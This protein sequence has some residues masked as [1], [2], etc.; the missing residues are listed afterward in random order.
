MLEFAELRYESIRSYFS[1]P[2]NLFGFLQ[3]PLFLTYFVLTVRTHSVDDSS[4]IDTLQS[5]IEIVL[6]F[7]IMSK[8]LEFL[9]TWRQYR[10]I[11]QMI[12]QV[13]IDIK[14]FM[15]LFFF[16]VL[17]FTVCLI[18]L[19]GQV[20][21]HDKC[22]G[23]DDDYPSIGK[24]LQVVIQVFRNSIGDIAPPM[25]ENW[26]D[27]LKDKEDI[28]SSIISIYLLWTIWFINILL[29]LIVML[30]FLIAEVG[31]TYAKASTLG[32]KFHYRERSILNYQ[33]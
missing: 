5:I 32:E 19:D 16:F 26:S 11:I 1:D 12:M 14:P 2:F 18:S 31:N 21:E 6:F 29:M 10:F 7:S 33:T 27:N 3:F 8:V 15:I 17:L 24:I 9:R 22:R 30:N 20:C 25:Y 13:F 28:G 4:S 23:D